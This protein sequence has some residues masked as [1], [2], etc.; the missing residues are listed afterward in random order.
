M[1]D[2]WPFDD[3]SNLAVLT[4]WAVLDGSEPIL[5]VCHDAQDGAWQFLNGGPVSEEDAAVVGLGEMLERD[6]SLREL[7]DLPEGWIAERADVCSP[8]MRVRR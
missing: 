5:R 8:W 4:V 2:E 6:P 1:Q 7:A 3:P